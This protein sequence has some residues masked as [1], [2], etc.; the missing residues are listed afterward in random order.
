M[1]KNVGEL[2]AHLGR[3][4]G[5]INAIVANAELIGDR[6]LTPKTFTSHKGARDYNDVLG[7][8]DSVTV[9]EC[10]KM[11][12]YGGIAKRVIT[13][14]PQGCWCVRPTVGE[15]E[16]P[17]N[18]VWQRLIN[19]FSLVDVFKKAH[20][21]S[22]IGQY[23]VI[24]LGLSDVGGDVST[25]DPITPSAKLLF[26]KPYSQL[27]A[28][29]VRYDEDQSSPRFGKPSRYKLSV[30]DMSTS[31][32]KSFEA[33]HS[34]IIHIS[35]GS[36]ES[37]TISDPEYLAG[38]NYL[39]DLNF[40]VIGGSAE[41]F[42]LNARGGLA[43]KT[44]PSVS[45]ATEDTDIKNIESALTAYIHGLRRMLFNEGV[46]VSPLS[47]PVHDPK[48]VF[49]VL[50]SVISA[51]YEIPKRI[52][53]GS[54][55]AQLASSQDA[56][57][58][59]D[60]VEEMIQFFCIPKIIKPFIDKMSAINE[61]PS[62]DIDSL[63]VVFNKGKRLDPV[64]QGQVATSKATAIA[65]YINSKAVG[66]PV[67]TDEQFVTEILGMEY[68]PDKLEENTITDEDSDDD[69]SELELD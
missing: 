18:Q 15:V 9:A 68:L 60:R 50:M 36:L 6:V 39:M 61:L 43:A 12:R 58:W 30:S 33:D 2:P 37:D 20:I 40:K 16:G 44:D 63:D 67:I 42:W 4:L 10:F 48:N 53:L 49:D 31:E 54:E 5:E 27:N 23:S 22:R 24:F 38:W 14:Y 13:S 52:L 41:M 32:V 8:P 62:A 46:D 11:Y 28:E 29:I 1:T 7:Y 26:V 64:K 25:I 51:V 19:R 55:Q 45:G 65:T 17:F 57:N 47:Y 69:E 35:S 59:A 34:R 3:F 21:L 66:N 56:S